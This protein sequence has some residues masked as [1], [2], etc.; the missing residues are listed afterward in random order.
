M[1]T[2]YLV[3]TLVAALMSGFS[4]VSVLRGA[5]FVTGPLEEYGVPRSWWNRLGLLKGAGAVG[6]VV[7][8]FVPV[9]GVAAGVGLVLYY[10]GAVATVVRA[11]AFGHVAFPMM[12]AGPVVVALV[13]M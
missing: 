11:R 5:A 7:G 4:A 3:L 13:L 12:Y 1:S 8:L 2:G 6:L 10:A 9:V